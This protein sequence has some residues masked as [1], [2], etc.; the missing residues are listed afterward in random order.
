M[1]ATDEDRAKAPELREIIAA[2]LLHAWNPE[3]EWGALT[4]SV[5]GYYLRL[6]D[7]AL[8]LPEVRTAA[9]ERAARPTPQLDAVKRERDETCAAAD[10]LRADLLVLAEELGRPA[11]E[12]ED[13]ARVAGLHYAAARL[14][15]IVDG[16][17]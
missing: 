12:N 8:A 2:A 10:Q 6:A 14:R 9:T 16:Q 15:A 13:D 3:E 17:R 11:F 1:S 7:V 5:R 4:E